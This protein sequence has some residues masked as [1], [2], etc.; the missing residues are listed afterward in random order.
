MDYEK[1]FLPA[2]ESTPLPLFLE[3]VASEDLLPAQID[4]KTAFSNGDPCENTHM[5][6][7]ESK[8]EKQKQDYVCKLEKAMYC[9]NQ[10]SKI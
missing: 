2:V 4:V 1:T 7:P 9:L 8:I 3:I 6:Q 5:K 10:V